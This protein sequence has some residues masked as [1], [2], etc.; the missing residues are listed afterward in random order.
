MPSYLGNRDF[1]ARH[2]LFLS[3]PLELREEIYYYLL[4]IP[5][6]KIDLQNLNEARLDRPNLD[7]S[8]LRVNK[9]V[10]EE[11]ST[12]LYSRNIFTILLRFNGCFLPSFV[13]PAIYKRYEIRIAYSSPWEA[14]DYTFQYPRATGQFS[15]IFPDNA[16]WIKKRDVPPVE[17]TM[18]P[19]PTYSHLIR[20]IQVQLIDLR[21]STKN[22]LSVAIQEQFRENL[23]FALLPLIHRL[24][25]LLDK[26]GDNLS[27]DLKIFSS[28]H[29]TFT[30]EGL[31]T[32][33]EQVRRQLWLP[34]AAEPPWE[35]DEGWIPIYSEL[36]EAAWPLTTLRGRLT[37]ET[38]MDDKLN[39]IKREIFRKCNAKANGDASK[40]FENASTQKDCIWFMSGGK[41][42]LMNAKLTE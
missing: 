12:I 33:R 30:R 28:E 36:L 16:L 10:H 26:A 29:L 24:R 21:S 39:D 7:L 22:P 34:D 27:V 15:G 31:D 17:P 5:K 25:P 40:M 41:R 18:L 20:H 38:P 35:T 32:Y 14:F 4:L 13:T 42:I 19:S 8:I 6:S 37:M 3:L 2:C 23:Q 9:Q 1:D 11:A